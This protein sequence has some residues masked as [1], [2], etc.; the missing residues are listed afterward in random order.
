[1]G[2]VLKLIGHGVGGKGSGSGMQVWDME[3]KR[4]EHFFTA[5]GGIR[6]CR[7]QRED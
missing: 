1:V 5:F 4:L 3:V 7:G 2:V 6:E